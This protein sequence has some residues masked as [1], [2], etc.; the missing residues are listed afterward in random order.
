MP[1]PSMCVPIFL[2][3][4]STSPKTVHDR[5]TQLS[6]HHIPSLHPSRT[7]FHRSRSFVSVC[8][9]DRNRSWNAY[10][11]ASSSLPAASTISLNS[12]PEISSSAV[13]ASP[14]TSSSGSSS[15]SGRSSPSG[16]S[17]AS[18]FTAVKPVLGAVFF[19]PDFLLPPSEAWDF[20]TTLETTLLALDLGFATAKLEA[21]LFALDLGLRVVSFVVSLLSSSSSVLTG[22]PTSSSAS[23][24]FALLIFGL[25]EGFLAA[26]VMFSS[27]SFSDLTLISLSPPSS[28]VFGLAERFLAAGFF[29]S[30]L[31]VLT[32]VVLSSP[33]SSA[34]VLRERFFGAGLSFSA[35]SPSPSPSAAL[36]FLLG[37][38]RPPS[39]SSF[40]RRVCQQEFAEAAFL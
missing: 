17:S 29:L 19:V 26:L 34:L 16:K 40:L 23:S 30:S 1:S 27:P 6:H 32:S 24:V 18:L 37:V 10:S 22:A 7:F 35:S 13:V 36:R 3:I 25:R 12:W 11:S 20:A 2:A 15:Y 14:L 39:P 8:T 31:S 5:P 4:V 21:S 28:S 38:S 9:Q 33:L